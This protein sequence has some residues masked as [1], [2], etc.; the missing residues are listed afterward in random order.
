[1]KQNR[2][3]ISTETQE[4]IRGDTLDLFDK[5]YRGTVPDG[6][7][8]LYWMHATIVVLT[9]H[10]IR[11][12]PM[13][14]TAH[15]IKD[16]QPDDGITHMSWIW[17]PDVTDG[18]LSPIKTMHCWVWLPIEKEIIDFSV[19]DVVR[20]RVAAG[21]HWPVSLPPY[22]WGRPTDLAP[23][24]IYLPHRDATDLAVRCINLSA[25]A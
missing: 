9:K 11:C 22:A 13:C 5:W 4:R 16:Y 6:Q 2:S 7:G 19:A 10:R 1:M 17:D 15:F 20:T 14:G 3:V 12:E 25:L 18:A 23:E 8:C 24:F 21:V